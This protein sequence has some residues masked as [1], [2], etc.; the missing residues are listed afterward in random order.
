MII[1]EYIIYIMI[2]IYMIIYEYMI[3]NHIFS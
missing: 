3:Q 2:I 1:Y